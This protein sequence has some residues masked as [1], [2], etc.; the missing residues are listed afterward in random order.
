MKLRIANRPSLV[1]DTSNGAVINTDEAALA[2]ARKR[3]EAAQ[4]KQ[5]EI[6]ELKQD[7]ADLKHMLG[8]I[9]KRLN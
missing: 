8:E 2:E 1:R 3:K 7:V 9:I 4:R 5:D 6:Q